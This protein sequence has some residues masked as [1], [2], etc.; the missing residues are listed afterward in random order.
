MDNTIMS[1]PTILNSIDRLIEADFIS[2]RREGRKNVYK[3]NSYNN[4]E[5]FSYEFLDK[6]DLNANEKAYILATQQH[7]FKDEVSYGTVSYTETELSEKINMSQPVINRCNN[8][9]KQK[10]YLLLLG[11]RDSETGIVINDKIFH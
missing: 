4:F 1:K 5:P 2:V 7:M 10:G 6:Q 3:F 11:A 9:L 8:S